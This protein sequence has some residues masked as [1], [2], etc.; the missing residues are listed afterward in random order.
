MEKNT[1]SVRELAER[2]EISLPMAYDLTRREDFPS[3]RVG[4]RILVPVDAF[5]EWLAREA[6]RKE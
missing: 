4:A 5:K 1:M 6:S 3:L 2:M